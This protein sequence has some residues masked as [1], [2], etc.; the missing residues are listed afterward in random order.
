LK[1]RLRVDLTRYRSELVAGVEGTTVG[2]AGLWSSGSDR[3]V[4]VRFPSTTIDVLWESLEIIDEQYLAEAKRR[5]AEKR[6]ALKSATSVVRY[7]GARG[8]F[9]YLSYQYTDKSGVVSH[10]STSSKAEAEELTVLFNQL[11]IPVKDTVLE[12]NPPNRRS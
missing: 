10:V 5:D 12:N 8:G 1:V 11:N 6:E 3:F 4:G 9:K 2:A 7:A